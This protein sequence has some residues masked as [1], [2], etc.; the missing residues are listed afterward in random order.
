MFNLM[1]LGGILGL[2]IWLIVIIYIITLA[3]RLVKGIERIA[4][5]LERNKS[6]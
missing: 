1:S 3:I 5:I 2:I 6:G 4:D